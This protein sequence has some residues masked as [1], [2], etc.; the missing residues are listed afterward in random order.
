MAA[1]THIS[2]GD[3]VSWFDSR[4]FLKKTDKSG[5]FLNDE[6]TPQHDVC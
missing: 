6:T 1:D 4:S 2:L 5:V 3:I